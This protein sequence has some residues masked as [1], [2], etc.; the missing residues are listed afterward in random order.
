MRLHAH[1]TRCS[2]RTVREH[3]AHKRSCA[4]DVL[5]CGAASTRACCCRRRRRRAR[6]AG[7]VKEA[8]Q[9]SGGSSEQDPYHALMLSSGPA[10]SNQNMLRS[11]R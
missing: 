7:G 3:S 8:L 9:P 5:L 6:E 4:H 10:M 2:L 1:N 11:M